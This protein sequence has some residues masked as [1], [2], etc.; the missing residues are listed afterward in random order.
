[1]PHIVITG[2]AACNRYCQFCPLKMEIG[3]LKSAAAIG[4]LYAYG[5]SLRSGYFGNAG[6]PMQFL[7]ALELATSELSL[8]TIYLHHL[9]ETDEQ[10]K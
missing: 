9:G 7:Q 10:P 2:N 1:M 3:C 8:M 6:N 5:C 4:I